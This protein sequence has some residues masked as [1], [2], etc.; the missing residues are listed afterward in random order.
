MLGGRVRARP[1]HLAGLYEVH[2]V[3]HEGCEVSSPRGREGSS[4]RASRWLGRN[5]WRC[6]TCSCQSSVMTVLPTGFATTL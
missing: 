2:V 6:R 3:D 4:Q 1:Q 5:V